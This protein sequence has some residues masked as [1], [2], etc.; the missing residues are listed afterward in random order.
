MQDGRVW[1]AN[2]SDQRLYETGNGFDSCRAP[3][4]EGPHRYADMQLD[5]HR[6]R[7]VCVRETHF[8]DD[9]EPVNALVAV[10]LAG[11]EVPVLHEG[12]DFYSNPARASMGSGW[13]G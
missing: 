9:R 7:L 1:F 11:G 2:D 6:S 10:P 13:R 5:E 4:G 3:T 12:H 8:E